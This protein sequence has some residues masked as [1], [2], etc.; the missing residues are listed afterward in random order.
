MST[1]QPKDCPACEATARRPRSGVVH[2][3]FQPHIARS[4]LNVSLVVGIAL[5]AINN[6]EQLWIQH[7][8]NLWHAAL[9]FV[10][11]FCVSSYSA[12]RNQA[13]QLPG[14]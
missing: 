9:N 5:N 3:M 1:G 6:G 11:P 2:L 14:K 8:I 4:A 10:V 13:R 7:T 12:A